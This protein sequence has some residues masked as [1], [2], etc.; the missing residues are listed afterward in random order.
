MDASAAGAMG[1]AGGMGAAGEVA[2]TTP[3]EARLL[4]DSGGGRQA[5]DTGG[6]GG[7]AAPQLDPE[8]MRE[9][10]RKTMNGAPNGGTSPAPLQ[11]PPVPESWMKRFEEN[12]NR[13]ARWHDSAESL[14][15]PGKM[16]KV[17]IQAP[18]ANLKHSE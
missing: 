9:T 2:S 17:D 15:L 16:E 14:L 13:A 4:G 5:F 3:G 10:L 12:R 7:G 8:A 1:P 6:G 18:G 11:P